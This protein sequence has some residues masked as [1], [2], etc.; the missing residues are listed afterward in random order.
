MRR[1]NEENTMYQ[2]RGQATGITK[3]YRNDARRYSTRNTSLHGLAVDGRVA[4][5]Q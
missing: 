1:K 2:K 5:V 3:Q 4:S